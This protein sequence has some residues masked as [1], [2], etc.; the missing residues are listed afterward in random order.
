[1]PLQT[2]QAQLVK[3]SK[4]PSIIAGAVQ[5]S[6]DATASQ[7][8]ALA[9]A[10]VAAHELNPGGHGA[11]ST[12]TPNKPV[13]RDGDGAAAF[14]GLDIDTNEIAGDF[15]TGRMRWNDTEKTVEVDLLQGR[16]LTLG[17]EVTFYVRNVSGSALTLGAAVSVSG[18]SNQRLAFGLASADG[19][20]ANKLIGLVKDAEGIANNGAGFIT[21]FGPFR[22][23]DTSAYAA[24]TELFLSTNGT[25]SATV[26]ANEAHSVVRI[27]FVAYSHASEG[28]IFVCPQFSGTLAGQS[29]LTAASYAAIRSLLG[30]G[31]AALSSS[32]AFD[33]A[34]SAA[35]AASA[36]IPLT[37]KG[38]ASG[39]APLGDDGIVSP[40]YL[41]GNVVT[42]GRVVADSTARLALPVGGAAGFVVKETSTGS[43]YV[44]TSGGSPSDSNA[45]VLVGETSIQ[46]LG[47]IAL[48]E[49]GAA[50]GVATLGSDGKVPADQIPAFAIS[51]FLGSV[52]SQSAMLALVGE[53]G[54]WCKRT[55]TGEAYILTAADSSLLASWTVLTDTSPDWS[56]ITNKPAFATVAT[57]GSAADLTG[58]LAA[59]RLPAFT[60]D[61]TSVA[62]T[63]V[64]VVS[65]INGVA[66][67]G[68]AT[69]ILKNTTGTGVPS[70]AVAGDFPTLNQST[71]GSAASLTTGRTIALTGDVTYT[72]GAFNG[73]ANVTGAATLATVN[74]N[75]GSFGGATQTPVL[76]VN[77]KGL[78]TAASVMTV[79][80]AWASVTGKPTTL[81]G[82]GITDAASASHKY[83]SFSTGEYYFDDYGQARYLRIFT[84]NARAD[85]FRFRTPSGAEYHNGSAWVAWTGGDM[86]LQ[87][88]LD[89]SEDTELAIDRT[90]RRF[91]FQLTSANG[92]PLISLL[93]LQSEWSAVAYTSI[94]VTLEHYVA[95]AWVVKET[96]TFGSATTAA[97]WGTH[98]FVCGNLHDGVTL[99]RITVEIADWVASGGYDTFRLRRLML[100]SNYSTLE[101]LRPWTWNFNKVVNFAAI[102]TANG[103]T[104][105]CASND[106]S[107]SGLDADLL[108]GSDGSFY[109]S[110][111]NLNAGTLEV[112][113]L[114]AFTGDA[115]TVAGASAITLA[116]TGVVASTYKSVTVDAKG[117]VTAGT[118]PTTLAGFGITDAQ[119]LDSDLTAYANASNAVARRALIDA[120]VA[121]AAAAAIL[122]LR[123]LTNSTGDLTVDAQ[124]RL[125]VTGTSLDPFT[126]VDWGNRQLVN[127][128]GNPAVSW[129]AEDVISLQS[130]R[131]V[132]DSIDPANVSI[133]SGLSNLSL[134][135]DATISLGG[136]R[137][138][139]GPDGPE[140]YTNDSS[141]RLRTPTGDEYLDIAEGNIALGYGTSFLSCNAYQSE[142][143]DASTAGLALYATGN[144]SVGS[145]AALDVTSDS[146]IDIVSGDYMNLYSTTGTTIGSAEPVSIRGS[147]ISLYDVANDHIML[148]AIPDSGVMIND[149]VG[150][151][152]LD[153]NYRQTVDA[154]GEFSHNWQE[155]ILY[156]ST[157]SPTVN[158]ESRI[159]MTGPAT[160][161]FESVAWGARLLVDSSGNPAVMWDYRLLSDITGTDS[162]DWNNRQLSDDSGNAVLSWVDLELQDYGSISSVNWGSR[163]LYDDAGVV[164]MTWLDKE[165]FGEWA[166]DGG[167]ILRGP[168][169]EGT[170]S[171]SGAGAIPLTHPSVAITTTGGSQ[172]MTLDNGANGQ[173]LTL[174]HA[175]DGGSAVVTPTTKTGFTTITFTNAGDTAQL[176]YLNTQ[177]WVIL[178]LRGATAA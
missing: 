149:A 178:S 94:V 163:T 157:S 4:I 36:S 166:F 155:R 92:Y 5:A 17:N 86:A 88:L 51:D 70:I 99:T 18:A 174:V 110:A 75:V 120:E 172:A 168:V 148:A 22:N 89:G 41:P 1:M 139:A 71:T 65:K 12:A 142:W 28:V 27:G 108:D 29:V 33:A 81:A 73:T 35:A 8:A 91:R 23:L 129:A 164:A 117:R 144:F 87:P 66:L 135:S 7:G 39:V 114:P 68:L 147:V 74:A 175:V 159:L 30:L 112:A 169:I 24:G 37:Q 146:Y 95:S 156:D 96:A 43:A 3:S 145:A 77:A 72:S 10:A 102:P 127:E 100:L 104:I 11:V 123:T 151:I 128:A 32:A 154:F 59:A 103:S 56:V 105:W 131:L 79:T 47:G 48:T 19:A 20:S 101:P 121:G 177:G 64:T 9:D 2:V 60:G 67:S 165:F 116:A 69:G 82:Y 58:T 150:N 130:G 111:S 137:A 115:T 25:Y 162:V 78:V 16:T 122:G 15:K 83:H 49:R 136:V 134:L 85:V 124:S 98:A 50:Y 46:A 109:R 125:L 84:E 106:G 54:D 119:P 171:R 62:G 93:V 44:L 138:E 132:I 45:W 90:H 6:L 158:Y 176:M 26:P 170:A 107:G 63:G 126:S 113:R 97:N 55:D 34:G 80:P 153:S 14:T 141:L 31:S 118:N 42:F 21:I 133:N 160:D 161:L 173:K 152:S 140:I 38:A 76:T 61:A 57:S 53:I 167:V 143:Y 13:L 40:I 52:A